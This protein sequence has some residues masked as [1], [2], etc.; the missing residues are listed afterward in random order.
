MRVH[1]PYVPNKFGVPSAKCLNWSIVTRAHIPRQAMPS[2]LE[3]RGR[4]QLFHGQV[5]DIT[6]YGHENLQN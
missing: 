5:R 1:V 6:L 4:L 2:Q 3:P